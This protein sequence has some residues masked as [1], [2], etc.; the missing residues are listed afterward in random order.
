MM[1]VKGSRLLICIALFN[2][3]SNLVN[4]NNGSGPHSHGNEDWI[5]HNYTDCDA[6]ANTHGNG[7]RH[8]DCDAHADPD[9]NAQEVS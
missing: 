7:Y 2:Q 8:T 6:H 3:T 1:L 5:R 4:A 9:E